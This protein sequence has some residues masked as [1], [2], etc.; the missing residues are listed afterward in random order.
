MKSKPRLNG[1]CRLIHTA[2][3][4]L[5]AAAGWTSGAHAQQAPAPQAPA[6]TAPATAPSDDADIVVTA[7]KREDGQ[8]VQDVGIAI[9]AFGR[10]QLEGNFVRSLQNLSYSA[11]NVQLEATGNMPGYANFS[12]RG[13][14][15]NSTIPSIEPTVGVFVDGV[16]M[17][18]NAGLVLDNFDLEGVE[19][20]RGPQGVLFGKNV[21]GGAVLLRTTTPG[22]TFHLDARVA[23]ETGP[24]VISSVVLSGPM[25]RDRLAGKIAV[26]YNN[27]DGWFRNRANGESLGASRQF[28]AR[29]ALNFTPTEDVSFVLRGEHGEFNGDGSIGQNHALFPRGSFRVSSDMRGFSRANWNQATGELNV[30]PSHG[31]ITNIAS[32]RRIRTDAFN[33]VDSTPLPLFTGRF[34]IQQHQ[35]S[36]ELRYA[37]RFGP[38]SLVTGLY[39]FDQRIHYVEGRSLSGG[40]VNVSGGGTLDQTTLGAF[41]SG[42]WDLS[43]TL[44]LNIGG[45]YSREHKRASV[46]QIRA[47]GCNLQTLVCGE[48]FRGAETWGSFTPK[49]GFQWRPRSHLQVYGFY[50]RGFRSGGY[51]LRSTDSGVPPGPFDQEAQDSFE[52]GAKVGTGRTHL[53]LAMFSNDISGLQR[54]VTVTGPLGFSQN[55][56]NTADATV[57]GIEADAQIRLFNGFSL[58]GFFGYVRGRYTR[59]LYDISGDGVINGADQALRLPRLSPYTYGAGF[60]YQISPHRLGRFVA[61]ASIAHRDRAYFSDNNLGYLQGADILDANL[62]WTPN[63]SPV[64]FSIY[65]RNLLNQSTLGTDSVLPAAFGGV[66]A[67]YSVLQKGRT[68]GGEMHLRL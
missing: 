12:I 49:F 9:S 21:T 44:T 15:V 20:L 46:Q 10:N 64:S 63:G 17:G 37:A 55:I 51:N 50:T 68:I 67:S 18:L 54:E 57:R 34:Q 58:T 32:Y 62:T 60:N 22:Q 30:R 23:A 13:Q 6:T 38:V 65:G 26:Y 29:S 35:F 36:D 4:P 59:I 53:N 14:G 43:D 25:I 3:L 52:L 7:T 19:V 16:Y 41:V 66:G 24:N 1:R 27:D 11:P 61:N 2:A 33:D 45:R 56:L 8:N 39:F 28:V 31:Q 47:G 5:C 42:D 40:A 48:T